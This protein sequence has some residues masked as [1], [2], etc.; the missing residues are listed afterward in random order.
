MNERVYILSS[1]LVIMRIVL[2]C[3]KCML[4]R[5]YMGFFSLNIRCNGLSRTLSKKL[6]C[7]T[8]CSSV[9]PAS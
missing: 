1:Q 8:K 4:Y 7:N 3:I 2:N 6:G 5:F 9:T